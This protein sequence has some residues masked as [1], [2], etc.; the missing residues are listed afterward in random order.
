MTAVFCKWFRE[1]TQG[2]EEEKLA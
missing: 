2:K 1:Q